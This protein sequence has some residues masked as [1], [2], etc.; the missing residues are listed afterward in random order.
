MPTLK[1]THKEL[2]IKSFA[3]YKTGEEIKE[4]LEKEYGLI[5]DRRQ[6][7]NYNPSSKS[8][9]RLPEKWK[10]LY[11]TERVRYNNEIDDV[12][13]ASKRFRLEQLHAMYNELAQERRLS[14]SPV[15]K[16]E[17]TDKMLSI[18]EQAADEVNEKG[19]TISEMNVYNQNNQN[20]FYERVAERLAG[21]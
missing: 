17:I 5:C 13:I 8:I 15:L 11:A 3:Q 14:E 16:L 20:N 9:K 10:A 1:D 4:L 12:G 18:L 6:I 7:A 2:I 21:R 19:V